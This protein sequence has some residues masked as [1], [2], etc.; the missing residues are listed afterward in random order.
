MYKTWFGATCIEEG[1]FEKDG[2]SRLKPKLPA[3]AC[4]DNGTKTDVNVVV[5]ID[6]EP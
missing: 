4:Q 5:W 2:M 1:C 3:L 6:I